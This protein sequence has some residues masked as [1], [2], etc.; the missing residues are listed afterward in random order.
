MDKEVFEKV[1]K[2]VRA[3]IVGLGNSSE[4]FDI[5]KLVGL[6]SEQGE[7]EL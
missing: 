1:F 6:N 2:G 7:Y 4:R 3:Q 5:S